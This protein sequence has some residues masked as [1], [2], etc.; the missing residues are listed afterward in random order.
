MCFL[1]VPSTIE[2]LKEVHASPTPR[3]PASSSGRSWMSAGRRKRPSH[4]SRLP[5]NK[6]VAILLD[7]KGPELRAGFYNEECRGKIQLMAGQDLKLVTDYS[8]E[9]DSTMLQQAGR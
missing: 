2:Q 1:P 9:G 7:A 5:P 3:H 8:Y 4:S 6:P